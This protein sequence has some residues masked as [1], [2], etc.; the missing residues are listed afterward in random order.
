MV[1]E[2]S[3]PKRPS[4]SANDA[5]YSCCAGLAYYNKYMQDKGQVPVSFCNAGKMRN[6][7]SVT[8]TRYTV[9]CSLYALAIVR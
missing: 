4:G 3:G 8:G 7:D 9:Y 2:S 1:S 6:R 5:K